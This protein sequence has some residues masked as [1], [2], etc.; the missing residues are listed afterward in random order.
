MR[1]EANREG[2]ETV[3]R[4]LEDNFTRYGDA[5]SEVRG[6]ARQRVEIVLCDGGLAAD[7][8]GWLSA[9]R[10]PPEPRIEEGGEVERTAR[11]SAPEQREPEPVATPGRAPGGDPRAGLNAEERLAYEQL[12]AFAAA[13][14]RADRWQAAEARLHAIYDH[15]D[16]LAAAEE[17]IPSA[18]AALGRE[19]EG[20]FTDGAK[21]M[22]EIESTMQ[23]DGSAETARRIRSGEMLG[24]EQRQITAPTRRF[25]VLPQRDRAAEAALRER[26]PEF[27]PGHAHL[28]APAHPGGRAPS[29]HP[30]DP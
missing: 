26:G 10:T 27:A 14:E 17:K 23:R 7:M 13:K 11:P 1:D 28:P 24:K 8:E 25:G 5:A 15:R 19:V 9:D 3:R 21:A 30:K 12:E 2:A 20:A 4:R 22:K 6:P 16:N 18:R 29:L